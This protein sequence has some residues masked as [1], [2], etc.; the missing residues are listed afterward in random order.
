MSA[1]PKMAPVPQTPPRRSFHRFPIHVPV[2]VIILRSGIPDSLPGRCTDLS[3]GGVGAVIAGQLGSGQQVA[4]EL[5]LPNVGVPVRARAIVRYH[6]HLRCG[7]QFLGLSAEQVGMIQ[8][9]A[10]QNVPVP[11]AR[12]P[13]AIESRASDETQAPLTESPKQRARKIRIQRRRL[14]A[15]L[16]AI[17]LLG[18]AGWWEWQRAWRELEAQ[19][20]TSSEPHEAKLPLR[21]SPDVMERRIISRVDPTYPEDA[22]LGK[23]E[24]LVILDAVIAPD[25]TVKHLR[26]IAGPYVLARSALDAVQSW[27]FEPYRSAGEPVEVETTVAIDFRLN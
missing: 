13:L 11:A 20:S 17:I 23:I 3:E 7:L 22:R 14:Y 19:A 8:Y 4:V 5:R 18:L 27:R 1:A 12:N 2:D 21:V 16:I 25:G 26:P 15:F 6:D 9:W 10:Y 24:G